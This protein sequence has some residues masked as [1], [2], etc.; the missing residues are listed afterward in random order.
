M[1]S[2]PNLTDMTLHGKDLQEEF[3]SALNAKASTLQVCMCVCTLYPCHDEFM[4]RT[5][6]AVEM[7]L[8]SYDILE[9]CRRYFFQHV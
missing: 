2:M 7:N 8:R 1:C 6:E 3:Y 9:I 4:Y 5:H